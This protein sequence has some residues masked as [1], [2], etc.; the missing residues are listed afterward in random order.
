MKQILAK[1]RK[2]IGYFGCLYAYHLF[3]NYPHSWERFLRREDAIDIL[4]I[5]H[6]HCHTQMQCYLEIVGK[7]SLNK[8]KLTSKL[9][10][11]VYVEMIKR[12][13]D[14]VFEDCLDLL[15]YAEWMVD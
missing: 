9:A 3:E 5:I 11:T 14:M 1:E 13:K 15:V 10:R 7:D 4:K 2:V 8:H 6:I 12:M